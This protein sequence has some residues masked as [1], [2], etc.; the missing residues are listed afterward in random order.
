M[1]RRFFGVSSHRAA[2]EALYHRILE[3]SRRPKFYREGGVAD[4][5]DGRFDL[6]VLNAFM[7]L[8]RLRSEGDSTS[9][10]N[11]ALFDV[12]FEDLDES[13]REIGVSDMS[14]GHKIKDMAQAFYGRVAAYEDGL[15]SSDE[16]QL[17]LA[18]GR[19]LYRN[20][21]PSKDTLKMMADYVRRQ[22]SLLDQQATVDLVKGNVCFESI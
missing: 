8:R 21:E 3:Q 4:T 19:N 6:L 17:E 16:T 12:M 2:G 10:L 14:I 13:L 22:L 18:L 15:A 7:V 11:Q 9:R 5:V 20:V 1:L